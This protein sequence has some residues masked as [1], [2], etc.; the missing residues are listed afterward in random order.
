MYKFILFL[1]EKQR[2]IFLLYFDLS[3][4][5]AISDV[6]LQRESCLF[7]IS[8][9]FIFQSVKVECQNFIFIVNKAESHSDVFAKANFRPVFC[10]FHHNN[11]YDV[12]VKNQ[13][14]DFQNLIAIYA[15]NNL[16]INHKL[17]I[18]YEHILSVPCSR[19]R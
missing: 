9:A 10:S 5:H 17:K 12:T 11:T 6:I 19:K 1:F 16:S 3:W 8:F 4:I 2:N 15:K 18:V 14:E 13:N 7:F